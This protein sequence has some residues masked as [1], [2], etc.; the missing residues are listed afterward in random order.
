MQ[1]GRFSQIHPQMEEEL[2]LNR[3]ADYADAS[4]RGQHM[5]LGFLQHSL[6]ISRMHFMLEM[7]SRNPDNRIELGARRQGAELRSQ[8]G[9]A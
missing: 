6:M 7:A 4:E 9:R 5:K 2:R 1:H 3:E 8:S